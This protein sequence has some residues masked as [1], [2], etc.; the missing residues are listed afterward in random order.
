MALVPVGPLLPASTNI[1]TNYTRNIKTGIMSTSSI[2]SNTI[3]SLVVTGLQ[4]PINNTDAANKRYVDSRVVRN[5]TEF[6]VQVQKDP[7]TGEFLTIESALASI[8]DASA[9]KPYCVLVGPGIYD[10]NVL[11]VP[12]YVSVK[13]SSINTTVV[14]PVIPNQYL[15]VLGNNTE[16]SF[17]TLQGIS[18]SVSPGA[19]SGYAAVYCEDVGDFAQMHKISIYDFDIGIQNYS[20][21][22]ESDLYVEYTDINGDYS[23]AIYNKSGTTPSVNKGFVSL[24]NVF[25]FPSNSVSKIAVF[26][27]GVNSKLEVN[28]CNFTGASGSSAVVM[29]NGG[30]VVLSASLFSDF[31]GTAIISRNVGDGASLQI[32]ACTF[33]NCSMDFN[34]LNAGT[35]GFFF[36]NSP[37]NNHNITDSNTQFFVASEDINVINVAPKGADYTS[38]KTAIDSITNSSTVN[39]YVVKVG[40]GVYTENTITMKTGVYLIGSATG[41]T[42][43]T[44]T[45]S[46]GTI[47]IGADNSMIQNLYLTG[48]SGSG[49]KAIYYTATTSTTGS[50][51]FV[52]DCNFANNDIHIDLYGLTYATT[53]LVE[54][55]TAVGTSST[56]FKL[57]NTSSVSTR[58]T[59]SEITY[60][61]L[62]TPE[63]TY[64]YYASGPNVFLTCQ[65]I[66]AK[67][68]DGAN[69]IAFYT[70]DGAET[71]VN[72]LTIKG[73]DT[74]MYV[75]SGSSNT[76]N[77]FIS[78][79]IYQS[80]TSYLVRILNSNTLGYWDS[81]TDYLKMSIPTDC[82]FY[83]SNKDSTIVTVQKSGGDFTSIAAAVNAITDANSTNR[84]IINVG[85]G[86]FVEPEIVM[87]PYVSIQGSGRAT[88]IEPDSTSH[89]IIRGCDSS[90]LYSFVIGGSGTGYAAIYQETPSGTS[91]SALICRNILFRD[92][93]LL[94]WTYG[95]TGQAHVVLFNCRYGG[96][97]SFTYGFR[98]T[99]NNNTVASKITIIGTT[100]QGFTSPLPTDLCYASGTN[101][102]ITLNGFNCVNKSTIESGTTAFRVSNGGHIH[103]V[104]VN[105]EGFD[106]GIIAENSGSGPDIVIVGT[107]INS[108][109]TDI[110]IANPDTVG[111]VDIS[112]TRTK[113]FKNSLSTISMFVVDPEETGVSFAGPFYYAQQNFS[114]I[115]DVSKLITNTPTMGL[116]TGGSL[117]TSGSLSIAVSG[118]SGYLD[119]AIRYVSWTTGSLSMPV[120]S[121]NYVYVNSTGLPTYSTAYPDT[122]QNILLGLV[123]TNGS[124]V[125]YIQNIPMDS[126]HWSN[127]VDLVLKNGLG[128]IYSSGS[129]VTET[130]TRQ[131]TVGQGT[132][133]FRNKQFL[134]AGASPATFNV[135][136]R[137][138]TAGIFST[139]TGQTTVPNGFYDNGT[140]TLA[141][142]TAGYYTKHLLCLLG[143]PGEVYALIYGQAEYSSQGAAEAAGLPLE[144]SFI[145]DAFTRVS[146]IVV[147]QGF[148]SIVSFIDERPR[149]GFAS[150]SVTGVVTVHGNLLGLSANDHPQY[151]L[152]DGSSTMS[153]NLNLAGNNITNV[154]LFNGFDVSAHAS[155][156]AFNGVDPLPAGTNSDIKE[157]SDSVSS[158]G[159][160]NTLVPRADHV[161]AHGNRGGGSLHATA[162]TSTAGFISST[163][164]L[165]LNGIEAGATNTTAST[166]SPLNVFVGATSAGISSEVSRYDHQHSVTTAAPTGS[167][168]TTSTNTEGSATS[169][170]RS[171]HV[172]AIASAVPSQVIPDQ[173]NAIG[174]ST[175]FARADH[176]HNI[177]SG[178][179]VSLD[180]NSSTSQGAAASFAISNHSHAIASGPPIQQTITNSVLTGTSGSFARADHVHTFLTGTPVTIGT[181]NYLGTSTAFARSDHIHYHGIQV[182]GNM[183]AVATSVTAGFMSASDKSKLDTV[184]DSA[185]AN[186]TTFLSLTTTVTTTS[187]TDTALT[188][189][190]LTPAAGNYIV[191]FS[192]GHIGN[193]NAN[194]TTT[195][196]VYIDSVQ[197]SDSEREV[198]ST[199]NTS[200]GYSVSIVTK[201]TV[202]GSQAI[203][204]RWRT[205]AN[206]S[207][208]S[209]RTL[210]LLKTSN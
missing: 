2:T 55:C 71:R 126:N 51:F 91:T 152:V 130:G 154:G 40:P 17:M 133:Y 19:G 81:P 168:L 96:S 187:L 109:N 107:S 56:C 113:I 52:R 110:N 24:E 111:S 180:A 29:Q 149:V 128:P 185:T 139:I 16:I 77:I 151:L 141:A 4:D 67:V 112:A 66:L 62:V 98:A 10:E 129:L 97:N 159:I 105:I 197:V 35:T 22:A 90:E 26:N 54:R 9:S 166:R 179:P 181:G 53:M 6:L 163:D 182:D 18:G 200:T 38:I 160:S 204:I 31:T 84:Y 25:T 165:K 68:F 65:N 20:N 147:Q 11:N 123:S 119:D 203:N 39:P 45:S 1:D 189:T 47:I 172:H 28:A 170:A 12:A 146:S 76:S 15:F 21:S 83:I 99:N 188:S 144:P 191:M 143:G 208:V 14:R 140:G 201:V 206:T 30:D 75:P 142:L 148:A 32:D 157:L 194:R 104:A 103:L 27:D 93:Y 80:I 190:T 138:S 155:R 124:Q 5:F 72:G 120:N 100:S 36:G 89:H 121:N 61:Q 92:N 82:L 115:T 7:G 57:T 175:G 23:Y 196:S 70:N 106:N 116:I 125:I 164:K 13:G 127:D 131:L 193:T 122:K 46:T 74:I 158:A 136:Y 167:L 176:I 95:N 173:T 8:T 37:R 58:M 33:D 186:P 195:F 198:F 210:T 42:V 85:A 101:C 192:A 69:S 145:T 184:E 150:S 50:V 153:G 205:S 34:I 108:C 134:P 209:V 161:H 41:A 118:G 114:D 88:F 48:A 156:H 174:N 60:Q 178:I 135:Y 94:C 137:S 207:S 202:N 73:F 87:K 169:L 171:D 117:S 49:G 3:T 59:L 78:S 79:V 199:T 132:Y 64:M 86:T 177:P 183:H 44:P 102:A 63:C 43:I 162:T